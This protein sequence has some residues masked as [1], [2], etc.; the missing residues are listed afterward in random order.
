MSIKKWWR[1]TA[2]ILLVLGVALAAG[3]YA[4]LQHPKFGAL[5]GGSHLQAIEHSP[6]YVNG[7]FRNLIDT[8][9]RTEDTSF[10]SNVISMLFDRNPNL[11][12]S[13]ALPSVHADLKALPKDRDVVVWLGHS[14]YF[15]Q[16]D[17][18]RILIDPVFSTN[19]GP[20]SGT[21]VAFPGTTPYT[22]D[23]MP[24]ID[25]LLVTHDHWDHLDYP[26]AK[27]LLPKVGQVIVGLGVGEFFD[28]WGYPSDRI[29]EA[30]WNDVLEPVPGLRIH[31][32]P[33]RHYSGRML[34]R[35]KTLWVAFALETSQRRLFFSGDSGYGPH[36]REIGER[37]GGFDLVALDMGQYD[38]RWANIHMFPE[39]AVQAAQ[40]LRAKA[41]LPAHVGRFSIAAHDWDEPLNQ[42]DQASQGRPYRLLTPTI[43]ALVLLDDETQQF[44]RWWKRVVSKA[45]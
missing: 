32:L 15:V 19:A 3:G 30:D 11:K 4:Y 20:F 17:G 10:V 21:N 23:D 43:G 7:E 36:F 9:M 44:S 29:H 12:P 5:P 26:S 35:N 24:D 34:T 14:S 28:R 27:A 18:K 45:D 25:V 40:D 38:K 42:I 16:L 41:L 1:R 13:V 37:F 31:V 39:Q 8:P 33:A 6:H 2:L 22:A